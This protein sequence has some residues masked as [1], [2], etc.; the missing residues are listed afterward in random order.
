MANANA[1]FT[2]LFAH[3]FAYIQGLR[4]IGAQIQPPFQ[5]VRKRVNA[6]LEDSAAQAREAGADPRDFDDARFAVCAW[7]DETLMGSPWSA[8]EEW[9]RNLLQS[10]LYGVTNA[11]E[12]FFERLLLGV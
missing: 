5:E 6:L 3:V 1:A 4:R 12:E 2:E 7:V 9:R 8:R 10:E 11:G